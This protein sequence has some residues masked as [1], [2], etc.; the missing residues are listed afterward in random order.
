MVYISTIKCSLLIDKTGQLGQVWLGGGGGGGRDY[1]GKV[2]V[3]T[4]RE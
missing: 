4:E 2:E 3:G 1:K